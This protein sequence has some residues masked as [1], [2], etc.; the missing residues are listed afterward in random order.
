MSDSERLVGQKLA[1]ILGEIRYL[2]KSEASRDS[3]KRQGDKNELT[4][5]SKS[6]RQAED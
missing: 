3:R 1:G 4:G 2:R 6:S 5:S